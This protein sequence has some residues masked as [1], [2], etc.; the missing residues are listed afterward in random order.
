M[1]LYRNCTS[2]LVSSSCQRPSSTS[3]SKYPAPQVN[4]GLSFRNL[5][6]ARTRMEGVYGAVPMLRSKTPVTSSL[7]SEWSR[8][9]LQSFGLHKLL[10]C[11]RNDGQI[12]NRPL[13]IWGGFVGGW[14]SVR[15][16]PTRREAKVQPC[17]CGCGGSPC[18][19]YGAGPLRGAIRSC[20]APATNRRT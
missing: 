16:H 10:Y 18:Q 17:V 1:T 8:R 9:H 14:G 7:P 20:S 15:P 4:W 11:K 12:C 3:C 13:S 6:R 5:S 2:T 19:S